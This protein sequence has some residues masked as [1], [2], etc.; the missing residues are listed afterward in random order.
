[1]K[2]KRWMGLIGLLSAVT[3]LMI[4]LGACAGEKEKP[5]VIFS[6][7]NWDSSQ[8]QVAIARKIVN[9]GYGYETDAVFGGTVPLFEALT[10]GD[11]NVTMEIWLPNQNEAYNAAL[12]AGTIATV[13]KSLEDNWQSAFIIPN[14]VAEANPGLKTPQDLRDHMDLFVTPDS[15]GKARLLNCPPG[16]TCET[17]NQAQ[18]KAYGLEDVVEAVNPG[19][20]AALE[21]AIRGAYEKKEPVLFYYWGPTTLSND[22]LT[23]YGG[24]TML[25]EPAYSQECWDAD[26]GCAYSIAEVL[27]AMRKD[28]MEQAP[29]LVSVFEKWDFSAGNQLAAEGYMAESGAEFPEV[30]DWFLKNTEQW[31]EWVTADASKK[32]LAALP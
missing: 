14:Y 15:K 22:L 29:E 10:R 24:F 16:W 2:M 27:I 30:A 9:L 11:T 23:E 26:K 8:V 21:A 20:G 5:T 17:V 7:L 6:D 19:S 18:I 31:K 3:V 13:G 25:E 32:I 12:A 28:L 4:V 1:M